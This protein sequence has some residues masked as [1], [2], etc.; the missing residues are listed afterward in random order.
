MNNN[1][2][3]HSLHIIQYKKIAASY[4][5]TSQESAVFISVGWRVMLK[6]AIMQTYTMGSIH[7]DGYF[8]CITQSYQYRG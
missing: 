8:V 3:V 5:C 4:K 7:R 6:H 2:V 1:L